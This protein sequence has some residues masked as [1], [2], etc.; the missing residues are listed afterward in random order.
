M[1]RLLEI[2]VPISPTPDFFRRVHFMA[3]SVRQIG[4][5][6]ADHEFVVCVGGDEEPVDLS[7]R[8]PWSKNYPITWRWVDRERFRA[9][10]YWETS[11]E[12][13]RRP[14]RGKLVMCADADVLFV[15]DFS[16]LLDNLQESPAVAGVIAH[17]PPFPKPSEMWEQLCS[18]YGVSVPP[19]I[20]EHTGWGFMVK[21]TEHR[22]TPVYFNFGMVI[23]PAEM[24]NAIGEEIIAADDLVTTHLTTFFRFQI[25]LTLAIQKKNLP[26]RALPLRYNFPNDPRFDRKYPD[27]LAHVRILH[28]LR[29]EIVHRENDFTDLEKVAALIRRRDLQGT[30]EVFRKRLHELY[31][32]VAAE[33]Q[34]AIFAN[35]FSGDGK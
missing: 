13:F 6:L 22:Y 4:G 17:A 16:E 14:A 23:A 15:R 20:H 12:I 31:P 8:L 3:A 27:E 19:S 34:P 32:V 26:S 30:N 29:C 11:R 1:S 25:A 24:M 21:A 18:D 7:E 10:N 28:Y 9:D 5:A 33:E 2:R 35:I